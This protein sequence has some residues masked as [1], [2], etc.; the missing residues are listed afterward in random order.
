MKRNKRQGFLF[1]LQNF[2]RDLSDFYQAYYSYIK[3]RLFAVFF[4]FDRFKKIGSWFLYRQRGKF[5]QPLAHF[6]LTVFIFLGVYLSPKLEKALADSEGWLPSSY[7]A[8]PV[9]AFGEGDLYAFQTSVTQERGDIIE[10]V[11]KEGE[12]LSA[13]A[14]KFNVSID[15]ISWANNIKSV[16][17]IKAGQRL[18]IPPVTGV[19]H[20]VKRGETVYSIAKKYQIDP[21]G[22]I[23]YPF[24]VFANDETFAL[25]VGQQLI[26]PNGIMSQPSSPPATQYYAQT[27]PIQVGISG[28]GGFSWPTSGR[29]TQ[30]FSWYHQAI[31]IASKDAPNIIASDG[32]QVETVI[33]SNYGYGNHCI[34]NHGNGYKTL[35]AHMSKIYVSAGDNLAK[36]SVIGKMGS[37][38]RSTGIHL[39]F[40]IIK[41]GVKLSPLSILQ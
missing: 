40:E 15:T 1:L 36:G 13:I 32:G 20:T 9:G 28:S 37:T 31:D 8:T 21:Q 22:I 33:Y 3:G 2:R 26:V 18:K 14:Q 39:H 10:Y 30:G 19:V 6:W 34:I 24:N 16:K 11:V 29:L 38:G 5:A 27:A 35:Y 7:L 25:S 17:N 41:D 23:D 12:T 4:K